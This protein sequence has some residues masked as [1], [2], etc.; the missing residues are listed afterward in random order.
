MTKQKHLKE[1]VRARM[2]KTGE[3]YTSARRHLLN[4][5]NPD[6]IPAGSFQHF[7]GSIPGSAALRILLANAGV[8]NPITKQ[9]FTEAMAFGVAGGIG[10]GIFSFYYQQQDFASFFVGGRHLWQDDQAYLEEACERLKLEAKTLESSS[11][12][13]AEKQLRELLEAG[14]PCVAW[15]DMALLPHRGMPK[16]M[17]GSGYHIVT[18]Y[19]IEDDNTVLV[20]DLAE[21]TIAIPMSDFVES[22][23][24]IKKQKNRLLAMA[25]AKKPIDLE[26]AIRQGIGAC[27]DGLLGKFKSWKAALGN[28]RLT[29]LETWSNRLHGSKDKESWEQVFAPGHRMLSGL[30]SIYEFIENYGTGGGLCRPMFATFLREAG[31]ALR[32]ARL[33]SLASRYDEIGTSWTKLAETALPANV[34]EFA[35][36]REAYS[37]RHEQLASLAGADALH[38]TWKEIPNPFRGAKE[39]FPLSDKESAALRQELQ[40]QV[41]ALYAAEMSARGDLV[42]CQK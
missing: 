23:A 35:R 13:A 36:I 11:S 31:E 40:S 26:S 42:L 22:R 30:T 8:N 16:Q 6:S 14:Q 24:R 7:A 5:G 25:P 3:S 17:A 20:G 18:V 34:P 37:L 28:F 32:D 10:I 33:K 2:S 27:C 1:R 12:K 41:K 19:A 39:K 15:V 29:A 9:P 4:D 21:D 38:E